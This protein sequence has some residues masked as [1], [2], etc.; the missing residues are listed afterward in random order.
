M[1][2]SYHIRILLKNILFLGLKNKHIYQELCQGWHLETLLIAR[3]VPLITPLS[4]ITSIAY[5]EQVG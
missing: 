1:Y 4:S 2:R 3:M 5:A